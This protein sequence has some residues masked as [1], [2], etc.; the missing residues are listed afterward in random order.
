[1]TF[2][3]E[4]TYSKKQTIFSTNTKEKTSNNNTNI[5]STS[6]AYDSLTSR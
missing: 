4:Y 3:F 5:Q 6:K 1:M 2:S